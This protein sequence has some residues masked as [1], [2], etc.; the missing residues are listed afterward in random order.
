MLTL[1]FFNS[2]LN[3][4]EQHNV[5]AHSSCSVKRKKSVMLQGFADGRSLPMPFARPG[6]KRASLP[7]GCVCRVSPALCMRKC[8]ITWCQ[9]LNHWCTDC[10]CAVVLQTAL[11]LSVFCQKVFSCA[12]DKVQ[13]LLFSSHL[14]RDE[15]KKPNFLNT[16]LQNEILTVEQLS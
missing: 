10:C 5:M 14:R 12:H 9:C 2:L 15:R 11:V 6:A 7:C 16:A 13:E 3:P 8:C 4:H 1:R